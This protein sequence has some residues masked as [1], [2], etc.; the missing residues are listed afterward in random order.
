MTPG[1]EDNQ[2]RLNRLVSVMQAGE[3]VTEALEH[4]GEYPSWMAGRKNRLAYFLMGRVY[5][6]ARAIRTVGKVMK[7][8][9]GPFE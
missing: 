8:V 4:L 5:S 2:P 7:A 6:R 3:T 9:F 1:V